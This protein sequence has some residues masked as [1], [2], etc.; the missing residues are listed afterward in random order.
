[1]Q[2]SPPAFEFEYIRRITITALFSDDVLFERLALKGGNALTLAY[3]ISPRTSLDLDFSIEDDFDDPL[4]IER[5]IFRAL[6]DRFDSAGFIVFDMSF[7]AKPRIRH[8]TQS[9]RWGGYLVRFK[10]I[11]KRKAEI[12]KGDIAAMRRD[13]TVIGPEQRR[14]FSIDLSKYEY[15]R[16][17]VPFEIDNYTVYVYTPAMIVL[18]KLRA[19][20]QQMPEYMPRRNSS[21]RA[22]D[23]FDIHLVISNT[24]MVVSASENLELARHIFAAKEVPLELISRIAT[25]KEFHRPDW[26][27]V[28]S[29]IAEAVEEFDYYF[30]FV[31]AQAASMQALWNK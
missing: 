29:F 9:P 27:S 14:V 4:D 1:M 5:R 18:E 28:K 17:K 19:I 10:V 2:I 8:E 22:R 16:G 26:E 15:T 31:V 20:C 3:R 7:E 21:P 25:Q 12:L 13:S 24:G 23:F 6:A 11:E 30:D